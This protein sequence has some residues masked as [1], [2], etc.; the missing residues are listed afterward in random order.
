MI[1]RFV[2]LKFS[3]R[4]RDG[5]SEHHL[6]AY[7]RRRRG[8]GAN[9]SAWD[10]RP[11]WKLKRLELRWQRRKGGK[12]LTRDIPI[13]RVTRGYRDNL[14]IMAERQARLRA[15]LRTRGDA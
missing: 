14:S 5:A 1:A 4:G 13:R 15:G 9:G 12:V 8:R 11:M 7:M 10:D 6:R 3:I 2:V